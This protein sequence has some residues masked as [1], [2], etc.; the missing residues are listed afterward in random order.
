[1]V[2]LVIESY[3]IKSYWG[4]EEVPKIYILGIYTSEDVAKERLESER[5]REHDDRVSS[6]KLSIREVDI[7]KDLD[8]EVNF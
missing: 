6:S 2:F 4:G 5:G 3:L 7:D 1:M 8:E